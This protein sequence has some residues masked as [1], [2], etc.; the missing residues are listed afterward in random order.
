MTRLAVVLGLVLMA[1]CDYSRVNLEAQSATA[2]C[3][4]AASVIAGRTFDCTADP[5][6]GNDRY[7][8][9]FDLYECIPRDPAKVPYDELYHCS[10]M[11]GALT[12]EQV[13][14]FGDDLDRWLSASPACPLIIERAD[15]TPL[16]GGI[17][18]E[19]GQ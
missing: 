16:P 2:A 1:G 6:L 15:G 18:T 14:A 17:V 10:L 11:V 4:D 9:F 13:K 5:N 19:G 8:L 7:D 12:C 3:R